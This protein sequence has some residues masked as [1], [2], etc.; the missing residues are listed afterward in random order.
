MDRAQLTRDLDALAAE[1]R[2]SAEAAADVAALD[3]LDLDVLGKKGRLTS[4]LRGIGSL[5]VD[6]RPKVGAIANDVRRSIDG[7]T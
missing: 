6:D 4:I 5:P 7:S 2:A 1:T 3:A